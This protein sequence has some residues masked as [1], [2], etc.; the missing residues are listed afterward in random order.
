ML[1]HGGGAEAGSATRV[2]GH[3]PFPR[4]ECFLPEHREIGGMAEPGDHAIAGHA[5]RSGP[6]TVIDRR[7]H[8]LTPHQGRGQ[9]RVECVAGPVVSMACTG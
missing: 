4:R 1:P 2:A 3:R 8:V 9:A 7:L 5:E 6:A